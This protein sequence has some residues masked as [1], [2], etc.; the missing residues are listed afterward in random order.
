MRNT[1]DPGAVPDFLKEQGTIEHEENTQV[2]PSDHLEQLTICV[3]RMGILKDIHKKNKDTNAKV[4]SEYTK[5]ECKALALLKEHNLGDFSGATHKIALKVS[6]SVRVPK[7]D[8]DKAALFNWITKNCGEDVLLAYQS[9]SSV[10]LNKFYETE[11]QLHFEKT[12][13][14]SFTMAGVEE[15]KAY[16]KLSFT[17]KRK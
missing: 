14:T 13:N 10:A 4:W 7:T 5:Y 6:S 9:I 2:L 17:K 15:P 12:G 11:A 8:E 1:V 3:D 16:E